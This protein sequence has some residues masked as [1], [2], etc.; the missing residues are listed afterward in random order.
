V[1][2]NRPVI[3]VV[4]QILRAQR[5]CILREQKKK[6][7]ATW[8]AAQVCTEQSARKSAKRRERFLRSVFSLPC[9]Q[10]LSEI[11]CKGAEQ[12]TN[13]RFSNPK[14]I[15]SASPGLRGTSYPGWRPAAFPTPTGLRLVFTVLPQPRWG[16]LRLPRC[17]RVARSSQPWA[18]GRNP[19]GI[20][21]WNFRRHWPE[22]RAPAPILVGALNTYLYAEG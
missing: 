7:R 5:G 20:R 16:C 13:Q 15:V 12:R 4:D 2:E 22:G 10:C 14:G 8:R 19:F 21:L 3:L 9:L 18:S 11:Q 6:N 17:P 1:K